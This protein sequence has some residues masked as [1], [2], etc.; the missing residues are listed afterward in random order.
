VFRCRFED[1]LDLSAG[2][3][4]PWRS[5]LRG[6]IRPSG[7]LRLLVRTPKLFR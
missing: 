6:K 1:W 7:R 4:D 5:L 3:V 2:R